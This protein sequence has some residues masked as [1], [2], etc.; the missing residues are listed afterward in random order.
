MRGSKG[1]LSHTYYEVYAVTGRLLFDSIAPRRFDLSRF[2]SDI[3]SG[4]A[5]ASDMQSVRFMAG[6]N[7]L[8]VDSIL[9]SRYCFHG[10]GTG[11]QNQGGPAVIQ[12]LWRNEID[13]RCN[14]TQSF[15]EITPGVIDKSLKQW[16][17]G[18]PH[19]L[20]ALLDRSDCTEVAKYHC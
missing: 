9:D 20:T 11:L 14:E 1:L 5:A 8:A 15:C 16:N 6:L 19:E 18:T 3:S 13:T 2:G 10:T 17:L 7:V 4:S 12:V